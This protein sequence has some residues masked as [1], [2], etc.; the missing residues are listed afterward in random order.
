MSFTVDFHENFV[1]MPT[2][3]RVASHPADPFS[4]Y[5][6]S[7]HKTKPTPPKPYSFMAH[8]NAPFVQKVLYVS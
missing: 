4:A 2:P 3:V 5:F 7:K 1:E 6:S 8:I